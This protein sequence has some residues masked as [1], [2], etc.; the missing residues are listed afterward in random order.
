[1]PNHVKNIVTF[2][3][4]K[5]LAVKI[6]ES[7]RQDD[8]PIGSIDFNKIIPMPDNIYKGDLSF[9]D[10]EKYGKDNWYDWSIENWG[11]KWNAYEAERALEFDNFIVFYTAWAAPHPVIEKLSDMYPE[12]QITH[13]WAD[14]DIGYNCGKVDYKGGEVID[15]YYPEGDEAV[16]F[17]CNIQGI[18]PEE[19]GF[20]L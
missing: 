18:P 1:M 8:E 4:D 19:L 10:L 11:T 9:N 16:E 2:N 20:D 6:I 5:D 3:G 17:A 14:E 13:C 12:I 15:E 7:I